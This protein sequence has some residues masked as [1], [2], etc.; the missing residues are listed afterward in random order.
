MTQLT[1]R[2]RVYEHFVEVVCWYDK[3]GTVITHEGQCWIITAM[4]SKE[5]T[6]SGITYK[7]AI[8]RTYRPLTRRIKV[9]SQNGKRSETN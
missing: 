3:V 7:E 2:V 9:P 6:L 1:R 8:I 5:S 4:S